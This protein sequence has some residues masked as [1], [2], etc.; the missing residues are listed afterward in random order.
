MKSFV[1]KL[2]PEQVSAFWDMIKYAIE[3]SLPPFVGDHP[4]I[5][6]RILSASLDGRIEVWAEYIKSEEGNKFEGI[7]LTQFIYDEPSDTKNLLI[8][9]LYGYSKIDPGS[10]GRVLVTM[11]KYAR[12]KRC[13]Q[14][15]AY[16]TVP[17]MIELVK[18]LGGNAD[19]TFISFDVNKTIQLLNDLGEV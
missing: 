19:Y 5:I 16:S 4:D 3:Q 17:H 1:T 6:N 14:I 15:I 2:L 8:Y 13:S 11:A 9:C 10:W 7:A 18:G 12:E